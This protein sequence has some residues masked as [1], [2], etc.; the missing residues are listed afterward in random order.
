M[1]KQILREEDVRYTT[2][3]AV[4]IGLLATDERAKGAG[5]RLMEWAV[6]YTASELSAKVG[7]RFMTVDALY[8]PDTGYDT[9]GFYA[10]F[11]FSYT[12]PHQK[13]PTK[14]P[15]REMFLDIKPLIDL[16][17]S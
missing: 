14:R 11:G 6:W 12:H 1:R 13:P 15:Y 8:D 16:I 7:V 9:S 5:T 17:H 10:R 3:P 4:K 2:F